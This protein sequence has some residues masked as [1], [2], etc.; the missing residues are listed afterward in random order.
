MIREFNTEFDLKFIREE[1]QK[2][3]LFTN[4]YTLSNLESLRQK[5]VEVVNQ[6]WGLEHL[7]SKNLHCHGN[8][9][10]KVSLTSLIC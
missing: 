10:P 6:A 3:R 8:I 5:L 9:L 7:V 1:S 2:E 4:T